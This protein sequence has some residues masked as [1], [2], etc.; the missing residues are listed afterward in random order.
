MATVIKFPSAPPPRRW[1]PLKDGVEPQDYL[2]ADLI[3]RRIADERPDLFEALAKAG[4]KRTW[5]DRFDDLD[6]CNWSFAA[7]FV[8]GALTWSVLV[9]LPFLA[10]W[11]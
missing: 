6:L 5:R 9:V 3:R 10:G 11:L 1:H 8:T 2:P 4:Y 7:G